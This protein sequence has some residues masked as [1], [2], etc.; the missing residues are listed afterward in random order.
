MGGT[1]HLKWPRYKHEENSPQGDWEAVHTGHDGSDHDA[2]KSKSGVS[3]NTHWKDI[4]HRDGFK[5][6]EHE[7]G[8]GTPNGPVHFDELPDAVIR[9]VVAHTGDETFHIRT[10]AAGIK[11]A[12]KVNLEYVMVEA[13][14]G[15]VW[16]V[17]DFRYFR[18]VAKRA[19]IRLIIGTMDNWSGWRRTL[20]NAVLA[21][22]RVRRLRQG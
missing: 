17:Q 10:T 11:H 4:W 5:D 1:F 16:T 13:K 12:A 14:P 19:G 7:Y 21:G 8:P 15:N 9:R 6:P 2:Q 3:Y 20:R 18:R 22:C